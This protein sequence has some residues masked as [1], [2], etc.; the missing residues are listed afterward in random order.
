MKKFFLYAFAAMAAMCMT[1]CSSDDDN[2]N[3]DNN[4]V[5][6]PTPPYADKAVQYSL[7][8]PKAPENAEEDAPQHTLQRRD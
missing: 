8:T 6:M 7:D 3:N 1:A 4:V 5:N 2:N